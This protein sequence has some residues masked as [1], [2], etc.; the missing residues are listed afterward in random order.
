[1]MSPEIELGISRT[2]GHELTNYCLVQPKF[3][4]ILVPRFGTP[5]RNFFYT[6]LYLSFWTDDLTCLNKPY[7]NVWSL[8][9]FTIKNSNIQTL[10]TQWPADIQVF[11]NKECL[12]NKT[13]QFPQA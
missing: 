10:S 12:R 13:V 7:M 3:F 5:Y 1:M 9:K 2:E 4:F 6:S 8:H 11:R